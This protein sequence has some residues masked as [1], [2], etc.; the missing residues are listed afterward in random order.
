MGSTWNDMN[1]DA[2]P[3]EDIRLLKEE[4]ARRD[5]LKRE[6]RKR[7]AQEWEARK[8]EAQERTTDWL[9]GQELEVL[10][11]ENNRRLGQAVKRAVVANL[12][13]GRA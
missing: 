2:S 13:K 11:A 5:G 9:V 6:A 3:I 4:L 10:I 1:R 12:W 7:K 8:R